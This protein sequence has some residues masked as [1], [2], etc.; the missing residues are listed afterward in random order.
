V[1]NGQAAVLALE[2]LEPEPLLELEELPDPLDEVPEPLEV[3][4]ELPDPESDFG[5]LLELSVDGFAA[6]ESDLAPASTF[7]V[8]LSLLSLDSDLRS[9]TPRASERLSLR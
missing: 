3:P 8:L 4:E 6:L 1:D 9:L 7:S 2:L 5:L